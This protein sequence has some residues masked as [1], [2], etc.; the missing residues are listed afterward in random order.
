M[1]KMAEAL[2]TA[3]IVKYLI[4]ISKYTRDIWQDVIYS[5][6]LLTC[7]FLFSMFWCVGLHGVSFLALFC[8]T[9]LILLDVN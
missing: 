6:M 3:S 9:W 7:A 4:N 5:I 2:K 1:T 8:E